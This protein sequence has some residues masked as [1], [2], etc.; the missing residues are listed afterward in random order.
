MCSEINISDIS[1]YIDFLILDFDWSLV[2]G[3]IKT[4]E[5]VLDKDY[6]IWY[7]DIVLKIVFGAKQSN[8]K[9]HWSVLLAT[10]VNI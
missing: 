6:T 2:V 8:R 10:L 5:L 3:G 4:P 7:L 9:K 1:T